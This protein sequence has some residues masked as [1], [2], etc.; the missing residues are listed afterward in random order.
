M[1]KCFDVWAP[2][3]LDGLSLADWD[4]AEEAYLAMFGL[5]YSDFGDILS[6]KHGLLLNATQQIVGNK[7]SQALDP[8]Q[9]KLEVRRLFDMSL[10]RTKME[11]L[12]VA[13][14]TRANMPNY[15]NTMP[16]QY[17]G[18]CRKVIFVVRG[19][20]NLSFAGIMCAVF[21]PV[22]VGF[23]IREKLLLEWFFV[24]VSWFI[25]SLVVRTIMAV[26]RQLRSMLAYRIVLDPTSRVL[27]PYGPY[28]LR[29]H[30]PGAW[31]T[32]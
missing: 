24:G 16:P 11:I 28:G 23:E 2:G 26:S 12:A 9:W 15:I 6:T 1:D 32:L 10:L 30:E 5:M 27:G 21:L 7:L 14:G 20:T 17:S 4:G 3:A 19:Y 18:M 31:A 29:S 25:H 8:E 13:R 22:L